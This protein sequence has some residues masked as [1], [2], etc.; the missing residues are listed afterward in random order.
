MPGKA[1]KVTITERQRD[2]LVTL[3]DAVTAPSHLRQRAAII[4]LAFAGLR[5]Q[6]ITEELGLGGRQVGR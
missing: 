6:D 4:L 2:I 5:N 1:A 3:R